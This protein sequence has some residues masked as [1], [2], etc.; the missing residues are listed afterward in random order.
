M[1]SIFETP[2]HV[3]L[4]LQNALSYNVSSDILPIELTQWQNFEFS[5]SILQPEFHYYRKYA[6]GLSIILT[7]LLTY[8]VTLLKSKVALRSSK[9]GREPPIVPYWIPFLGNL[10]PFV[11]DPFSYCDETTYVSYLYTRASVINSQCTTQLT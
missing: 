10:L 2:E 6:I 8:T 5:S 1:A 4:T 9:Y 3:L 11:R 7:F